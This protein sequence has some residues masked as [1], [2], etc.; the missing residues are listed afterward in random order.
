MHASLRRAIR[1]CLGL[2]L[3]LLGIVGLFLPLLQGMLFISA[4]ILLLAPNSR[5]SRWIRRFFR[6]LTA[7]AGRAVRRAKSGPARKL[8]RP[9]RW[10]A[11]K[12]RRKKEQAR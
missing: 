9:F 11:A 12:L 6:R 7:W 4:G 3:I 1:I 5:V 10:L 8:R 2:L